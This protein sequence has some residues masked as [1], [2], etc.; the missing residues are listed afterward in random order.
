DLHA[1]DDQRFCRI[2]V[3]GQVDGADPVRRGDIVF[4]TDQLGGAFTHGLS[5]FCRGVGEVSKPAPPRVF[6]GGAR[7]QIPCLRLASMK[8]SRSPSST[9]WVFETS[10]LVRRSLMR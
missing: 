2:E 8:M 9:F 3:E 7:A 4:A 5:F 6:A 1:V 10:T